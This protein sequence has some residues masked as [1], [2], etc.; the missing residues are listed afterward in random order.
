M[1]NPF[2]LFFCSLFALWLAAQIGLRVRAWLSR[3]DVPNEADFSLILGSTLTLLGLIIGFTFAMAVS[4]YDQRKNL[5]EEEANAIGTEYLRAS[6]LSEPAAT[7]VRSLLLS[8]T[9]QRIL[10]YR[11]T[12]REKL[13]AI[14]ASTGQLQFE[15]WSAV[16]TAASS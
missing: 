6:L 10:Y 9:D 12:E 14:A 11:T 4:R 13:P 2:I 1:R 7:H 5:E 3:A 8:Y 16:A 15:L